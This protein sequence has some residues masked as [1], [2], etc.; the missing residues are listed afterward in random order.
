MLKVIRQIENG[1]KKADVCR[2]FGLVNSI[3][4]TIWK[5]RTKIIRAFEQN[6]SR[7]KRS[8]KPERSDVV[9]ALLK[10]FKQQEGDNVPVSGPLLMIKAEEFAKKLSGEE[11]VRSAGWIDRF[12]LRHISS[13]KRATKP[14]VFRA[15]FWVVLPCKMIV[16][17]RFRGA[18]CLHH[19][20]CKQRYDNIMAYCRVA[21]CAQRVCRLIFLTPMRLGFSLD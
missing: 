9:E 20:G 8:R 2:E 13:G 10:W 7:I 14:G 1:K 12:K 19:Q 5:N 6:G 16:G 21:Q 4:Q 17:R 15:V 3:I 11:F 18:Y